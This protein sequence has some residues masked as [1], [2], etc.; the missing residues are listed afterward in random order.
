[1]NRIVLKIKLL[2][3]NGLRI[4]LYHLDPRFLSVGGKFLCFQTDEKDFTIFGYNM[5]H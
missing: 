5:I 1:M 3:K 4:D 2:E